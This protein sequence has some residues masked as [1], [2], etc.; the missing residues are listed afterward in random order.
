M[1]EAFAIFAAV[2]GLLDIAGRSSAGL[3]HA[4]KAWKSVP[5]SL[6]ALSNEVSD[7]KLVLDH[8][9]TLADPQI[10]NSSLEDTLSQQ[11]RKASQHLGELD[12]LMTEFNAL[13]RYKQKTRWIA[14]R[15]KVEQLKNNIKEVRS[16]MADLLLIHNV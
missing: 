6:L 9:A 15:S 2:P 14:K 10:S 4:I 5:A 11:L 8:V 12:S 16:K 7:L 13:P 1:A 3:V